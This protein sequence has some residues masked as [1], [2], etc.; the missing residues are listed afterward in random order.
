MKGIH[1]KMKTYTKNKKTAKNDEWTTSGVGLPRA[2]T[3]RLR[4]ETQLDRIE[5]K[6]D[7]LLSR[8]V[9]APPPQWNVPGFWLNPP[10]REEEPSYPRDWFGNP[11]P[12][13]N[14]GAR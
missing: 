1:N 9:Y 3:D 14:G 4:K 6:L 11:V 5:R 10:R 13:A 12:Y 8:I 7:D 2:V